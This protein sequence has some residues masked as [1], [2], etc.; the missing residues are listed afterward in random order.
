M[1]RVHCSLVV[2]DLKKTI[3]DSL[4]SVRPAALSRL[5]VSKFSLGKFAPAVLG[6]TYHCPRE[7]SFW[8]DLDLRVGGDVDVQLDV[9]VG[10]VTASVMLDDL[11]ITGTLRLQF[12]P[13][14]AVTPW[15]KNLRLSFVR[16]PDVD[17]DL[18][19]FSTALNVM[20]VP[21]VHSLVLN[22]VQKDALAFMTY[23]NVIDMVMIE[24]K[25]LEQAGLPI[26]NAS[27]PAKEPALGGD[28][29]GVMTL[30]LTRLHLDLAQ[31]RSR[32]ATG[33]LGSD[34]P[35]SVV[36]WA[37]LQV[38]VSVGSRKATSLQLAPNTDLPRAS[39]A[40]FRF[41]L[42]HFLLGDY[43]I[44]TVTRKERRRLRT[45]A[46]VAVGEVRLPVSATLSPDGQ[47]AD[48]PGA[49]ECT[50][51][52][53]LPLVAFPDL[54]LEFFVHY[55]PFTAAGS[56]S[57]FM[58]AARPTTGAGAAAA[59]APP[60]GGSLRDR[61]RAKGSADAVEAVTVGGQRGGKAQRGLL[62]VKVEKAT[63]LKAADW[64]GASDPYVIL[65][66]GDSEAQRTRVVTKDLN[67][68]WNQQFEFLVENSAAAHLAVDVMDQDTG[69]R[70][71]RLG[72]LKLPVQDVAA[73]EQGTLV[74]EWS[75]EGTGQGR[76]TLSQV[77]KPY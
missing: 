41:I 67:P 20:A 51:Q 26:P 43:I 27:G 9:G 13:M 14:V 54:Q 22:A 44:L 16:P 48:R 39:S 19:T 21:G 37:D 46:Q 68:V 59:V 35:L 55:L 7:D 56:E 18:N 63:D 32:A 52:Q 53:R 23:P 71:D 17:F 72:M 57:S 8:L 62:I 11:V 31:A 15:F 3:N 40:A 66:V 61:Q 45:D 10:G 64:G 58:P 28:L 69:T 75:L 6:V 2:T 30:T 49:V 34:V 25:Y 47:P 12:E 60:Q 24:D 74:G 4:E 33:G 76:I 77:W 36:D 29:A 38:E 70:D 73:S 5:E 42:P 1:L 65:R 50:T